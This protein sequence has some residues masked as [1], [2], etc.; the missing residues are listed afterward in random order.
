MTD[1][2]MLVM[3][4]FSCA[5]AVADDS[6]TELLAILDND[7]DCI[8]PNNL[9]D[10]F[11]DARSAHFIVDDECD[12]LL[13][14]EN[15]RG[16]K[17]YSQSFL[18]LTIAPTL[19]C[20]FNCVY[21]YE[22]VRKG[23]MSL[24]VQAAI[25][26]FL[27]QQ[28]F[29]LK[30]LSV[31]WYGGEPLLAPDVISGMATQILSICKENNIRFSS[32]IVTN[33]SLITSETIKILKDALVKSVQITID[34]PS[35]IH[36]ARRTQKNGVDSYDTIVNN[37]N[38]LLA[39]G[40]FDVALRI[41]ID[42][43]NISTL[44]ELFADLSRKLISKQ[45]K[46]YVGQVSAYTEACKSVENICLTNEEYAYQKIIN[47]ELLQ[48]YGFIDDN[49]LILYPSPK[50]I[51]CTAQLLNS[52]VVDPEGYLYKCW[53]EVGVLDK[54]IGNISNGFFITNYKN[55][56]WAKCNPLH[57]PK[58]VECKILPLCAGGC[59]QKASSQNESTICDSLK[60]NIDT[61][62]NQCYSIQ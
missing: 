33:G 49:N 1:G 60:Y 53:N 7:S 11:N 43:S 8:V 38:L 45:L 61:I 52:F 40:C 26:D 29:N 62:V 48:K 5:L 4:T 58:C 47:Y 30:E 6:F 59:P 36:N 55:S 28:A 37:V 13:E 3:N 25:L 44:E 18:D 15:E 24:E 17:Q 57:N 54:S 16:L 50:Y 27:R 22:S 34:G 46:I 39:E 21:C 20:N 41:N 9:L 35:S 31:T 32:G 2:T 12:E 23:K 42:K 14:F 10:C 51:Y 19:A 56:R